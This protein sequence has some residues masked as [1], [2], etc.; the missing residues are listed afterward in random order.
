MHFR[1]L[2]MIATIDFHAALECIK[3]VFGPVSDP[4]PAGAADSAPPKSPS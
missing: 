1:I 2:K 4:D 3:F